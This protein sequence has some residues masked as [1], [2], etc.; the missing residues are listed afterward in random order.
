MMPGSGC[1]ATGYGGGEQFFDYVMYPCRAL[2]SDPFPTQARSG[3]PTQIQAQQ[4]WRRVGKR[5]GARINALVRPTTDGGR[6]GD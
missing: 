6:L 1:G 2:P 5:P 3:W 4:L